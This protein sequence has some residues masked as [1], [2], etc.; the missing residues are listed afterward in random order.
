MPENFLR[1]FDDG[2]GKRD[3]ENSAGVRS[4]V[5]IWNTCVDCTIF[6]KSLWNDGAMPTYQ[7]VCK[8]CGHELEELQ[9]MKELPLV[10]CP[11]CGHDTLARI[12]SSGSGLI[13]KGSGFYKTDYEKSTGKDSSPPPKKEE[14]KTD[15]DAKPTES[16]PSATPPA[17]D[18]K[19]D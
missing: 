12:M 19:K 14:K 16:K 17:S 10:K 8:H 4:S 1:V 6:F 11:N 5:V 9:S 15:A 18:S 3:G 2:L 13:F 7:Y